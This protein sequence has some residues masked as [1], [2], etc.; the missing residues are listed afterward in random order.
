MSFSTSYVNEES[1]LN[2]FKWFVHFLLRVFR[3]YNPFDSKQIVKY[4]IKII[5][6]SIYSSCGQMIGYFKFKS[7]IIPLYAFSTKGAKQ[8]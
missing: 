1:N 8:R 4:L 6:L 7:S 3:S 2:I 5:H